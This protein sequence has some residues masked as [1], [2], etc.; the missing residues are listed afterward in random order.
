LKVFE[1]FLCKYIKIFYVNNFFDL[2]KILK[3]ITLIAITLIDQIFR[4]RREIEEMHEK[5]RNEN[6]K[7]YE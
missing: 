7:I 3:E 6:D 2:Q 4:S 5:K 1:S